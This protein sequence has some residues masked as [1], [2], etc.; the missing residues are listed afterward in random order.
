MS[1]TSTDFA[2]F[3]EKL[4]SSPAEIDLRNAA[5]RGYY[6]AFH[7]CHSIMDRCPSN[8][9]LVMGSHE[10]LTERLKLQG[11]VEAKS[12]QYVL[13]AMKRIRTVADYE[14]SD[15]FPAREAQ[16]QISQL[17][18]LDAKVSSF[19]AKFPPIAA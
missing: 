2:T 11:S 9:H 6:S 18:V 8:A 12:L 16:A 1:V 14:I 15:P 5:S 7:L 10:R 19:S 3:A 4:V 17:K 13:I